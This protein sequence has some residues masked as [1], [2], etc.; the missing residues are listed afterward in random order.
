MI[1]NILTKYEKKI[2]FVFGSMV[3]LGVLGYIVDDNHK[4]EI[5][6]LKKVFEEQLQKKDELIMD[7]TKQLKT[8]MI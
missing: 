3:S 2:M 6:K 5:R 1:I 8:N 7:L 4:F